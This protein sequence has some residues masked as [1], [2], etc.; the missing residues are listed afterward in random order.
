MLNKAI[1]FSNSDSIRSQLLKSDAIYHG[2]QTGIIGDIALN[3]NQHPCDFG[4][5]FY[6][7][8]ML[9]QAEN[10]VMNY[11]NPI[12]YGYRFDRNGLNS[13][14][15]TDDVQ[16]ALFIGVCRNK[17]DVTGYPKLEE[18]YRSL[19]SYDILEG[20]IADDKIAQTFIEFMDGNITDKCL[21]ACLKFVNYGTQIV[22]ISQKSLSHLTEVGHYVVSTEQ[23]KSS[24][25][26]SQK[27][28]YEMDERLAELK[29]LYRRDGK[30]IDECLGEY[31]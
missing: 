7:S 5:G 11:R 24:L 18:L 3:R 22:F 23:R 2:S 17:I 12:V 30:F 29:K 13:Y 28:K 25:D 6:T 27:L 31:C 16:W 9:L 4:N 14:H 15:F 1:G 10:R 19:R 26:W 8:E 20:L 21:S